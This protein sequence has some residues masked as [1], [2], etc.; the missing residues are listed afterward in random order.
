MDVTSCVEE[1]DSGPASSH[2]PRPLRPFFVI[3]RVT[4]RKRLSPDQSFTASRPGPRQ[5]RISA[6]PPCTGLR[7]TASSRECAMNWPSG[8][9][10]GVR[11]AVQRET[12]RSAAGEIRNPDVGPLAD[13]I[14][15]ELSEGGRSV[16]RK[17]RF[18]ADR[19]TVGETL[20][21]SPISL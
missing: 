3:Q 9:E 8:D 5:I 7:Y 13:E 14:P 2:T 6:P 12:G 11:P 19:R 10:A 15:S 1:S 4:T 21:I 16:L 18:R 17:T 20:P